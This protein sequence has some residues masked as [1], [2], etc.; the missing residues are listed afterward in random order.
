VAREA[1]VSRDGEVYRA[2]GVEGEERGL[3]D[4]PF[5]AQVRAAL[6]AG[7]HVGADA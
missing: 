7:G 5:V 3:E 4:V 1:K 2:G 6:A